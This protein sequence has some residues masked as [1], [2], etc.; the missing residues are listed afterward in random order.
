MNVLID[1]SGF[2]LLI[3]IFT[4]ECSRDQL[5]S[6]KCTAISGRASGKVEETGSWERG[7]WKAERERELERARES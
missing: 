2:R 4:R 1:R 3:C 6:E 7:I 5:W